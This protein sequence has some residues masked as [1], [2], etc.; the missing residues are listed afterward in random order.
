VIDQFITSAGTKWDLCCGLVMLL[1]HGLEGQGAEHSSAR[2]ER[3]LQLC[4]EQNIQVCVPTTPAQMFHLLRRQMLRAFRRPLVVMTPKSLLRHRLATSSLD[5][6][7]QGR[8]QTVIGEQDALDPD[9]VQRVVICSGKVYFDL[10]EA[11]RAR[12]LADVAI[13]RIEQL[14]PFPKEEFARA[15]APYR[16]ATQFIWCQ[17]EAQNQGPWDQ[18]KHRFH[19]L[20]DDGRRVYYVGRSASAAPAVGHRHVHVEQQ[21]QLVDEALTGRINPRQNR[22]IPA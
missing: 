8:F 14:Y 7:E 10:I 22:R 21:E 4:A 19:W 20:L 17:E 11:R 2:L 1:P 9:E 3:Y 16:S 18:I 5:E 6:L 12:G 15:I 13:L